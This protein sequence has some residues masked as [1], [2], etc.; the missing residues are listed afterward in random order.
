MSLL[1]NDGDTTWNEDIYTLGMPVG[2]KSFVAPRDSLIWIN[3]WIGDATKPLNTGGGTLTVE[4]AYWF[5]GLHLRSVIERENRD[6]TIEIRKQRAYFSCSRPIFVKEG[7]T[8]TCLVMSTNSNDTDING[9]VFF[10][11]HFA[12][13]Y[14][15]GGHPQVDT[16]S[17]GGNTPADVE[18]EVKSALNTAIPGSPV[19]DS[20]NERIKAIDELIEAS[21]DGDLKFIKDALEGDVEIDTTST[22]WQVVVKIKGTSTE[23]IRKDLKDKDGNNITSVNALIGRY[24]EP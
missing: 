11:D 22:P 20:V 5:G 12:V 17:V 18:T 15:D 8:I 24:T 21:G 2:I 3:L 7:E 4:Y 6:T 16:V 14:S 1:L 19:T 9:E 13:G 23:L 10:C